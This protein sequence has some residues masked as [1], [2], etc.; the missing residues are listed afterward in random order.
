MSDSSK[1]LSILLDSEINDFYSPP[2]LTLE[3][4]RLYFSLND[5]EQETFHTL[6]DRHSSIYFVLLLGYFKVKPVVIN[7]TFSGIKDDFNYVATEFYPDI[8][9]KP[10]N[11][12]LSQKTRLYRRIF[13]LEN[14]SYFSN[15]IRLR[16]QQEAS[17]IFTISIE[18]RYIFDECIDYLARNK[19]AIPKY[20]ILLRAIGV[21]IN[22]GKKRVSLLI[23]NNLSD[24]LLSFP[25]ALFEN[26]AKPKLK[27]IRQTAKDFTPREINKEL[28][29][30][31]YLESHINDINKL[32]KTLKLSIKNIE[33]YA[34]MVDYY[35]VTKLQRFEKSMRFLYLLCYLQSL[36]REI[37]EHLADA[38]IFHC[39]K[40]RESTKAYAKETSYSE[41][42]NAAKNVIK[43]SFLLRW[44][45]D[46]SLDEQMTFGVVK[47]KATQLVNAKDIELLCLY[48][49]DDKRTIAYYIWE[50]YD[51]QKELFTGTLRQ[52][53]MTL[54]FQ[55][56]ET[57]RALVV[58]IERSQQDCT[59]QQD[60]FNRVDRRLVKPSQIP[61]LMKDGKIIYQRFEILLYLL[62]QTKLDGEVFILKILKYRCLHDDLINDQDWKQ[63]S[64]LI[65]A[66][67]LNRLLVSPQRLVESLQDELLEKIPHVGDRVQNGDNQ[68]VIMRNR[69]GKTKWR[70]PYKG[71]GSM[72]NNPFF[73]QLK[74]VHVADLLRFVEQETQFLYAFEHV[75]NH[76]TANPSMHN[77]LIASIIANG[78]NFGLY[79]MAH[80]SDRSYEQLRQTQANY[81]RLE[82]FNHANDII[83]NAVT[84]LPICAL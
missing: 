23:Q 81:I 64:R 7:F 67:Q 19:I 71:V 42:A 44:Y 32:V 79:R 35:T 66:S 51:Q 74:Q 62:I 20:S 37:N 38:F 59:K 54:K 36:H 2:T 1:R 5:M 58:Q 30:F 26:N 61:Y 83:S 48:L 40:L 60:N 6:N 82:T 13:K 33:Y 31:N 77:D 39:R 11:L 17:A 15:E 12:S 29:I 65:K 9:F 28:K 70:L 80:I 78:T 4:Q 63:K 14:Y 69:T 68:S 53:F 8:K 49:S 21:A 73:E 25:G 75:R 46:D 18:S 27:E 50:F 24:S 34:S 84:K 55:A 76:Q 16:M 47:K 52:L 3:Q 22:S 10:R 72:L 57:T 43:A 56:S 41:W 45:V